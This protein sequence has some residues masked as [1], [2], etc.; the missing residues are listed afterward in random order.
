MSR[1][2]S[3]SALSTFRSCPRQFKFQ[4]VDR[5]RVPLGPTADTYMG[6]AVHRVLARLYKLAADGV[7]IPLDEVLAEYRAE[8]EKPDSRSIRVINERLTVDDYVQSGQKMLE[9]YYAKH[10]P[11]DQGTLLGAEINITFGLADTPYKFRAVIDRLW[12]RPD[13]VVEIIDYKTGKNLPQGGRDPR[14]LYQMGLYQ[15][16]V[17]VKWPDFQQVELAQFY[18]K[19]DEEIRY[20]MAPEE[21]DEL[22]ESLRTDVIESIL[23]ERADDFPT[24]ESGLCDYCDFFELCP[25]KRHARI[26]QEE[27]EA[28]ENEKTPMVT[29]SELAQKYIETDDRAKALKAE[30]DALKEDIIRVAGELGLDKLVSPAGEVS[31]RKSHAEKFI[32]K[33]DDAAAFADLSQLARKWELDDYF[34]LDGRALMKEMYRKRRFSPE[35]ADQIK[36]Y[37]IEKDEVRVSIRRKKGEEE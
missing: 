25:A 14:F 35:Q 1:T 32:T 3:H 18:L 17:E 31:V 7:V 15:L 33:T 37:V 4:Y 28:G 30:H 12:K 29:A 10:H 23:A 26:L 16:A 22:V 8:W 11:F 9:T 36:P 5:V 21:L 6:T 13:G 19:M 34:K 27:E 20:R 2:Y 24:V